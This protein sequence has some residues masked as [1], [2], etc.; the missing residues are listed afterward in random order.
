MQS[1]FE[2]SK[3]NKKNVIGLMSG[4]SLDGVDVA[5]IEIEGNGVNTKVDLV[6]FLEY[7]FPDGLKGSNPQELKKRKQQC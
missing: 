2:L 5:L 1:L 4:T 3:K 7:P 6:G